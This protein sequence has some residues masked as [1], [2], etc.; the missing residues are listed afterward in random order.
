[1]LFFL[2]RGLTCINSVSKSAG[3][4][5]P[6][7]NCKFFKAVLRRRHPL[8]YWLE[9]ITEGAVLVH[10]LNMDLTVCD[11]VSGKGK[12]LLQNAT[13]DSLLRASYLVS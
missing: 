8:F 9:I 7:Q 1:M 5:C 11:E 10:F 2:A 3:R 12:V 4:K 6:S 13:S